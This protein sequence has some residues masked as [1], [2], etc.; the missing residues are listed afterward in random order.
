MG[1][2]ASPRQIFSFEKKLLL[3]MTTVKQPLLVQYMAIKGRWPIQRK[4]T[5]QGRFDLKIGFDL[6][7]KTAITVDSFNLKTKIKM[8]RPQI[9]SVE[10][11]DFQVIQCDQAIL[12][13]FAVRPS[14]SN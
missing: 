14:Y 8:P 9:L 12:T 4:L 3:G 7:M 1:F 5:L 11:T 6:N 2:Q 13:S 10:Q